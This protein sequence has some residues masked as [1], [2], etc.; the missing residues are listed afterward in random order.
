MTSELLIYA[1]AAYG[2][3][4]VVGRARVSRRAREAI[5]PL[6]P[7]SPLSVFRRVHPLRYWLVALVECPACFGYWTGS[8]LGG[9]IFR[10]FGH[11]L[12]VSVAMS[13]LTVSTNLLLFAATRT[14]L[15]SMEGEE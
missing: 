2:L 5:A 4:Y 9:Y 12:L 3:W 14:A 10:S 7:P 6:A 13:F 1:L 15:D 8:I 11:W